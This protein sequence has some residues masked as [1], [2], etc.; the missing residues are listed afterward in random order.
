MCIISANERRHL[1]NFSAWATT[2]FWNVD[3]FVMNKCF[4]S[5]KQIRKIR[6]IACTIITLVNKTHFPKLFVHMISRTSTNSW[7]HYCNWNSFSRSE[8]YGVILFVYTN[9]L[10]IVCSLFHLLQSTPGNL[11]GD[12]EQL[13]AIEYVRTRKFACWRKC[14]MA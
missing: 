7:R 6:V 10:F 5:Y 2:H 8:L 4:E 11:P 13:F 14:A 9:M 1:V 12:P 3:N